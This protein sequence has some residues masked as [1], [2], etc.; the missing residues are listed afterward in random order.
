VLP[1][2]IVPVDGTTIVLRARGSELLILP[3]HV[4]QLKVLNSP[5]EF[6]GYFLS[7]A[8]LNRPARKLFEAWLRKDQS[9]WQRIYRTIQSE[10][11]VEKIADYAKKMEAIKDGDSKDSQPES[12]KAKKSEKEHSADKVEKPVAAKAAKST[13]V[14]KKSKAAGSP[15]ASAK[16]AVKTKAAAPKAAPKKKASVTKKTSKGK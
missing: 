9:L 1:V 15:I 13:P 14:A 7:N 8:L 10:M 11:D 5:K 6:T 2:E 4:G 3:Q 16:K 12:M